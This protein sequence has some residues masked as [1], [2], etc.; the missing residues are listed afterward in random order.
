MK[1]ELRYKYKIKRKY[2]QHS[3]REVAEGAIADVFIEAFSG[4]STFFIYYSFG[5]EADTHQLISRLF[6]MG[7]RVFLPRVEGGQIVAVEYTGQPLLK[8]AFGIS[9]PQGQAFDGEIDVC[10]APLLAVDERGFRLGYGGGYYNR[11]FA[12][13]PQV[14]KAGIGFNLQFTEQSFAEEHDVPLDCFVSE[15]G[16][17]SFGK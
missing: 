16:I 8:G 2:F 3:A 5:S 11:Y 12:L 4:F 13:H 1:E 6:D 15:R 14:I 7:K 10:A 17:I 9:E